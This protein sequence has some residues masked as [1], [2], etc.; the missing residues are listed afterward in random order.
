[1]RIEGVDNLENVLDRMYS[2]YNKETEKYLK[3]I[4]KELVRGVKIKTP[5]DTG[6]LRR[7]WDMELED[8]AVTIGTNIKYAPYVEHGHRT[9]GGGSVEGR[10]MLKKSVEEIENKLDIEFKAMI[11]NLWD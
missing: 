5:V 8:N 9:R 6:L 7:S 11:E 2:N 3:K 10:Y 4:G 1:M